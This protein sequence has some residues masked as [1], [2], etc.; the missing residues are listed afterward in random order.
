MRRG[1]PLR[2]VVVGECLIEL[3]RSGSDALTIRPAGDT[4][5]TASMLVRARRALGAPAEV[6]FR[7]GLGVDPLSGVIAEAMRDHGL[8]DAAVRLPRAAC[9]LYLLDGATGAMWYWRDDSAARTLFHG[10]AWIPEGSPDLAFLSLITVQ[11]MSELARDR[12]AEWLG[13]VRGGGGT[14]A[15]SANHRAAGWTSTEAA[16]AEAARFAAGAD[17]VFA[18][19]ADCRALFGAPGPQAALDRLE[20]FGVT[21]A[22]VTD[23]EAGA[24]AFAGGARLHLPAVAPARPVDATGAGDAFAGAYLAW[25]S[26]GRSPETAARAA[27]L[28]ASQTVTFLGALPPNGSAEWFAMDALLAE[29]T[30]AV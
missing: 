15:F 24:V 11:Q 19:V 6:A 14:V 25:R 27:A 22:V 26:A 1:R 5:N 20:G 23:A 4:F 28:V 29:L 30:R 8:V 7:T 18:S 3:V 21:E 16:A 17:L 2:A 10:E 13:R 9:G 12:A